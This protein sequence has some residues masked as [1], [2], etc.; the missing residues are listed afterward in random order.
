[1]GTK[2]LRCIVCKQRRK[3]SHVLYRLC[4]PVCGALC[5]KKRETPLPDLSGYVALVTGARIGVGE[6]VAL[7]LLRA[8]ACVI[9]ITRFPT[10]AARRYEAQP[11]AQTWRERLTL[12]GLDFRHVMVVEQLAM[13]LAETLPRLDL[14]VNNAAQTLRLPPAA[15][16]ALEAGEAASLM[17]PPPGLPVPV[18]DPVAHSD[19]W[20]L[21][22]S[23]VSALELVEAQL[24]NAVAP[25]LL[26]SRLKPL[27][28]KNAPSFVVN[29]TS[30][31][32]RF[33]QK[34]KSEFH[35]HTNMAKA[36]LNIFTRTIADEYRRLGVY[37]NAVDP[38]WVSLQHSSQAP[39][40]IAAPFDFEDAAARVLD[41]VIGYLADGTLHSGQLLKDFQP[42]P[43]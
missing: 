43:W 9:G 41:P 33:E 28:Q 5:Q 23:E 13:H 40:G 4:C 26:T 2:G 12:H 14:L 21:R 38:G 11:D 36:A 17:I 35:P 15:Y 22:D 25:F 30:Q 19:S 27:L 34:R 39:A 32:G 10:D 7:R 16:A 37:V 31:E 8:G 1:M 18:E 29:V 6:A 24:I 42:A 3:D 20:R